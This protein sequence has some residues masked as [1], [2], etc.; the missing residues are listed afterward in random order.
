M[1]ALEAL[2]KN[3]SELPCLLF[4]A[5]DQCTPA[6]ND[7]KDDIC[8]IAVYLKVAFR[9]LECD[10]SRKVRPRVYVAVYNAL[11][12]SLRHQTSLLDERLFEDLT[13]FI[14]RGMRDRERGVRLAAGF[15]V[16][17]SHISVFIERI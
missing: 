2:A 5:N 9:I 7:G 13:T 6:T 17:D 11:G 12:R 10:D 1:A 4:H 16:F 14:V 8:F 15:V 3:L